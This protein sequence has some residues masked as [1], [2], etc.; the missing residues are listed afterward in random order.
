MKKILILMITFCVLAVSCDNSLDDFSTSN[1]NGSNN[2]S[3]SDKDN[4]EKI[5]AN[6]SS[7]SYYYDDYAYHIVLTINPEKL[8]EIGVDYN[9][10]YL[11]AVYTKDRPDNGGFI[12]M[13]QPRDSG[14]FLVK[15]NSTNSRFDIIASIFIDDDYMSPYAEESLYWCSY[16]A[17]KEKDHLSLSEQD[18]YNSVVRY[19]NAVEYEARNQLEFTAYVYHNQKKYILKK[20]S[21]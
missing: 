7:I 2:S 14:C 1:N 8:S 4:V 17:L 15:A 5:I 12:S 11:E 10:Y 16:M 13:T 9:D 21:Y 20:I 18:L 19:M 3:S 6:N